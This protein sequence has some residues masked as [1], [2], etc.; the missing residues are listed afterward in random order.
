MFIIKHFSRFNNKKQQLEQKPPPVHPRFIDLNNTGVKRDGSKKVGAAITSIEKP[1][2]SLSDRSHL[3]R[4]VEPSGFKQE[5]PFYSSPDIWHQPSKPISIPLKENNIRSRKSISSTSSFSHDSYE[6]ELVIQTLSHED[7]ICED[8]QESSSFT[9][10]KLVKSDIIATQS[11]ASSSS[12]VQAENSFESLTPFEKTMIL[13]IGRQYDDYE[14]SF[15]EYNDFWFKNVKPMEGETKLFT[16]EL[17]NPIQRGEEVWVKV[18]IKKQ[19]FFEKNPISNFRALH[20]SNMHR[21]LSDPIF[22]LNR[23]YPFIVSFV[24]HTAFHEKNL[25]FILMEYC[26]NGTLLDFINKKPVSAS[27]PVMRM[28]L[29]D[30]AFGLCFIHE[31]GIAHRDLKLENIF[32]T[33]DKQRSRLVAKIGDFGHAC[34]IFPETMDN[35]SLCS[36]DYAAPELFMNIM[37]NSILG[38]LW[39]YGVCLYASFERYFPFAIDRNS[40]G[41]CYPPKEYKGL[42]HGKHVHRY[43]WMSGN[44]KF[45]N[46]IEK[47]LLFNPKERLKMEKVVDHPFFEE[48]KIPLIF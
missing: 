5:Y 28:L 32:L 46:L 19:N 43:S 27:T 38:D 45:I 33:W 21:F 26:T 40:P 47:L 30:V 11:Q 34:Q 1:Q 25:H 18:A 17:K 7:G 2:Q 4:N 22:S 35:Y 14:D 10:R 41:A 44:L 3:S 20:E 31:N 8:K 37:H 36:I 15:T 12:N 13:G 24:G 23:G 29:H 42:K 6:N 16:G 39:S 9:R 48:I